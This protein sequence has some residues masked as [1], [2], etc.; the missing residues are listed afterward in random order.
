ME[1]ITVSLVKADVGGF[2]GHSTVR[3][4]LKENAQEYFKRGEM[5]KQEHKKQ[6]AI[7]L[8]L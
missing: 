6:R 5:V 4:E 8:I 2:P 7:V 3:P 1:K